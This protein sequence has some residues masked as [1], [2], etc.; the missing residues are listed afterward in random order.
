MHG[1]AV[2]LTFFF[3]WPHN[4]IVLLKACCVCLIGHIEETAGLDTKMWCLLQ[5]T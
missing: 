4:E 1:D 5:S 2:K 3:Q